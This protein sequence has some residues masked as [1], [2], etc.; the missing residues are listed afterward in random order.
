[1]SEIINNQSFD[2][3]VKRLISENGLKVNTDLL[4][5]NK[6]KAIKRIMQLEGELFVPHHIPKGTDEDPDNPDFREFSQYEKDN[7]KCSNCKFPYDYWIKKTDKELQTELMS[8]ETLKA[9]PV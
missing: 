5:F 7:C 1:M 2:D 9:N 8:L 6:E 3:R 4:M